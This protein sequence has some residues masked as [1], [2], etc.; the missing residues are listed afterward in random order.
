MCEF[1]RCESDIIFQAQIGLLVILLIA[2]INCLLGSVLPA[3]SEKQ[4]KGFVGY[5]GDSFR[6]FITILIK[7]AQI[8]MYLYIP[9][10]IE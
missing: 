7:V 1:N 10:Q 8:H 3:T 9:I 6:Y 5:R 2:I 4:A